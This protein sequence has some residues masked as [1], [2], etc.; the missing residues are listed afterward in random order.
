L[1]WFEEV[2]RKFSDEQNKLQQEMS[3]QKKEDQ[4]TSQLA[5]ARLRNH[6]M[7]FELLRFSFDGARI[8]F[9]Y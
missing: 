3:K 8:F 9:K 1:H 4:Q 7:E 5:K 6:Q 2:Q